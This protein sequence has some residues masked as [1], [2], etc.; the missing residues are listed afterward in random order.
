MARSMHVSEGLGQTR[1]QQGLPQE[2]LLCL[3]MSPRLV[4]PSEPR[5]SDGVEVDDAKDVLECRMPIF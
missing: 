5:L 2:Y 1:A 4:G 3:L